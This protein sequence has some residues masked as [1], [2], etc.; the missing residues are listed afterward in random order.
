MFVLPLLQIGLVLLSMGCGFVIG[1]L[2]GRTVRRAQ[3]ESV[4]GR[5]TGLSEPAS[6]FGQTERRAQRTLDHPPP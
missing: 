3:A 1:L 5:R 2:L 4:Q 6:P